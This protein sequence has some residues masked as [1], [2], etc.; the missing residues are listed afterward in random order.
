MNK[1]F[2]KI[3]CHRLFKKARRKGV[4]LEFYP[5]TYNCGRLDCLWHGGTIANVAIDDKISIEISAIG[6]VKAILYGADG[7]EIIRVKDTSCYGFFEN[8]MSRCIKDD[9]DLRRLIDDGRLCLDNKNWLEYDGIIYKDDK[10]KCKFIDLGFIVDN[11]LDSTDIL[12]GISEVLNRV[13][14]IKREI[15]SVYKE[16]S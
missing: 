5:E 14:E 2:Y 11:V 4:K 8:E 6:D 15:M 9:K 7:N 13:K 3:K 16:V 12:D 10:F 1:Y